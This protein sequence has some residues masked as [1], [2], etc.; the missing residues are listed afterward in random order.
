[1]RFKT[2]DYYDHWPF[3]GMNYALDMY[4]LEL[5]YGLEYKMMTWLE[6]NRISHA[7]L[8]EDRITFKKE[9]DRTM[10]ILKFS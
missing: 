3:K 7:W 4:D 9:Q 8:I 2:S 1:M 6:G 5:T 10:F